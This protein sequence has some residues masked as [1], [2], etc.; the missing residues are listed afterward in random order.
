MKKY[1]LI[2]FFFVLFSCSTKAEVVL[3]QPV[4]EQE[5]YLFHFVEPYETEDDIWWT[6]KINSDWAEF[7]FLNKI[8]W[9]SVDQVDFN[10]YSVDDLRYFE[11]LLND[12]QNE[13]I[14]PIADCLNINMYGSY[15]NDE[16]LPKACP[17][18]YYNLL[19]ENDYYQDYRSRHE[20]KYQI[21]KYTNQF[22]LDWY[23][24]HSKWVC[25]NLDNNSLDIQSFVNRLFFD[26]FV[27]DQEFYKDVSNIQWMVARSAIHH[28]C[29][30]NK[31][32]FY[33]QIVTL[34]QN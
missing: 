11:K 21:Y 27:S 32:K 5:E 10:L 30:E 3:P 14:N 34:K 9:I 2:P 18:F 1:V 24:D 26:S 28:M 6:K 22:V 12:Y 15:L 17:F 13:I 8:M 16:Y 31:Q 7:I 29:P 25:N 19:E 23:L 33:F 4:T 20:E